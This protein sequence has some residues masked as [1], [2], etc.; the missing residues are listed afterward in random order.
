MIYKYNLSW[1]W[2]LLVMSAPLFVTV[3]TVILLPESARFLGALGKFDKVDRILA[4]I[5]KENKTG[6]PKGNLSR[7]SLFGSAGNE[8]A[9][10]KSNFKDLFSGRNLKTTL[11]LSVIWFASGFSYYG[12]VFL[13]PLLNAKKGVD[14]PN[15]VPLKL[16]DYGNLIWTGFAEL[17]GT[18]LAFYALEYIGRK[19]TLT[20]QFIIIGF[21]LTLLLFDVPEAASF[22]AILI[23]RAVCHSTVSSLVI[24]TP[25]VYPTFL[26]G[27]GIGVAN[28]FFRAGGMLTPFFS[29]VTVEHYFNVTIGIYM[30]CCFVAAIW[31][32]LLPIETQGTE[33]EA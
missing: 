7:K 8:T 29:Q 11:L 1:K 4:N 15:C 5:G 31:A 21:S 9:L 13:I 24:Y 3:L 27:K 33:L 12:V 32:I 23:A 10:L 2:H 14:T 30:S 20:V 19:K 25:E 6:L 28:M 17:P 18:F 26:R 22:T 16:S